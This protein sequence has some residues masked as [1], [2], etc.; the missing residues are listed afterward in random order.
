VPA[1]GSCGKNAA[2]SALF[3]CIANHPSRRTFST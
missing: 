2:V 1:A 3:H